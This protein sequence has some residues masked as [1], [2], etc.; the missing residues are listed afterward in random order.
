MLVGIG[1]LYQGQ[2]VNPSAS[3]PPNNAR[4]ERI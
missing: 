4:R 2:E 3:S 1:A